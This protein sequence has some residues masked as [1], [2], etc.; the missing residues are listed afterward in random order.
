M[1]AIFK[2]LHD[3]NLVAGF[4]S[5]CGIE[6]PSDSTRDLPVTNNHF[7]S[8]SSATKRVQ[9]REGKKLENEENSFIPKSQFRIKNRFLYYLF[10]FGSFLGN[11]EFYMLFF[12]FLFWN[13][14]NLAGKPYY[15][16]H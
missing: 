14:D 4:Q 2:F 9:F 1:A 11:E 8:S 6:V 16:G 10:Q 12:P 7:I 3:P 13:L 5:I 15:A